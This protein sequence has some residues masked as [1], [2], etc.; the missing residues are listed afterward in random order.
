M[1]KFEWHSEKAENNFKKHNVSFEEA[2]SVFYDYFAYMF[3]DKAHS[4]Y[5]LR[6]I[7]IGYSKNNRLL[8]VSFTERN[9]V[10]RIISARK[11]TKQERKYYEAFNKNH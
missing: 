10:I 2:K 8:F 1:I 6:Y 4:N 3:S 9:D 5:E 11:A 7:L